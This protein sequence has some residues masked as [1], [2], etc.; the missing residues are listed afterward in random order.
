MSCEYCKKKIK[1][2]CI[3]DSVDET[4]GILVRIVRNSNGAYLVADGWYDGFIA[5]DPRRAFIRFC[6]MC[7]EELR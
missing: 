7:G 5:I 4:E 2:E 6:P 1:N 3:I